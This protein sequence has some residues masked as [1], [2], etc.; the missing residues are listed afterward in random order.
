M[1]NQITNIVLTEKM[2]NHFLSKFDY[3]AF[4]VST[5]F[6]DIRY[7]KVIERDKT[8]FKDLTFQDVLNE[9]NSFTAGLKYH[10]LVDEV[11]EKY[12]V[13]NG[14]YDLIPSS[15][16][17]TQALKI[18][19]DEVLYKNVLDWNKIIVFLDRVLN[20]EA[21]L[22]NQTN[23]I[24]EWH[25]LMQEYFKQAPTDQSRKNFIIGVG[26]PE[27]IAEEVN[28][29][30]AEMRKAPKVQEIILNLY[31]NWDYLVKG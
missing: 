23:K 31:E 19:E 1:A 16:F 29:L 8:H 10:S 2:S 14:V 11:R 4:I 7:L 5:V 9:Q 17:I 24:N 30:L 6:P 20:E 12:M 28:N 18:Y 21:E 13:E 3:S 25:A 27:D 22:V 26:Y 15:K